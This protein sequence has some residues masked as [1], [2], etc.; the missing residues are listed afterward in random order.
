MSEKELDSIIEE[1]DIGIKKTEKKVKYIKD[2]AIVRFLMQQTQRKD[3]DLSKFKIPS[4]LDMNEA[5]NEDN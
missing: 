1:A 5:E 4:Y 3:I 2:K